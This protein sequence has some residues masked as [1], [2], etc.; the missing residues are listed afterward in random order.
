MQKVIKAVLPTLFA[1]ICMW[2]QAQAA[3]TFGSF[4]IGYRSGL[5]LR[6]GVGVNNFATGFP[7]AL[8]F[9]IS[10]ARVD[11]G[12][13]FPARRVFIADATNGTPEKSGVVWDLR[14]DFLYPLR[15]AGVKAISV[16]A[17]PRFSMFDA[18]FHYVGANEEFD[19]TSNQW[20][21][22]LGMKGQFAMSHR[23]DLTLSAGVDNYFAGPLH[24]HDTTYTPDNQNVNPKENFTYSDAS[25]VVNAPK[26]QL[27]M[28]IGLTYAF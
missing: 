18:G 8:E 26:I 20:G 1:A 14:M 13:P 11:A 10:Y 17:G 7:L 12:D 2:H 28:L 3:D 19:V 23:V 5:D 15:I 22:G 16:F 24:G 9:A 25:K 4:L 6:A 27:V 21:L